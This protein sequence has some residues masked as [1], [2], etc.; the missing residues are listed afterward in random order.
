MKIVLDLR[1][2]PSRLIFTDDSHASFLNIID[3]LLGK[4]NNKLADQRNKLIYRY[5]PGP[6]N[7]LGQEKWLRHFCA[8]N[9]LQINDVE[10]SYSPMPIQK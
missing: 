3:E 8:V 1:S 10:R 9:D 6:L 4:Y 5:T 7:L 2:K